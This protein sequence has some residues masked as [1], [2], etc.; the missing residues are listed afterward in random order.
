M[1]RSIIKTKIPKITYELSLGCVADNNGEQELLEGVL[2]GFGFGLEDIVASRKKG[3][4]YISVYS[5]SAPKMKTLKR[6]I[7]SLKLKGV[8]IKIATLLKEEWLTK[9]KDDFKPFVMGRKFCI[10]PVWFKDKYDPKTKTPIYIDTIAAFGT[11]LHPTTRFMFEFIERCQG[12]FHSFLDIG[13]GTGI[14]V[15]AALHCGAQ[16]CDCLDINYDAVKAAKENFKRNNLKVNNIEA[17][18]FQSF[19]SKKKYDYVAANLITHD[20][21]NMKKKILRFVKPN[22]YL[23]ISGIALN[24]FNEIK[25][26][27]SELPL[28]CLKIEKGEGWCAILYKRIDVG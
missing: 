18:D 10:I 23:A 1:P 20:L 13:T 2:M 21:L 4:D 24:N 7:L 26:V 17:T 15:M 25:S 5:T 3:R 16:W 6:K 8:S 19:Q 22:Q 12:S 28:R 27:Y 9:W 14:L 11:G